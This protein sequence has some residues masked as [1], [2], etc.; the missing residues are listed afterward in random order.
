[1]RSLIPSRRAFGTGLAAAGALMASARTAAASPRPQ[2]VAHRGASGYRPEHTASAYLLAIAQGA[3][4]IEPDLVLTKD[5]A[6]VARHENEIGGTTDVASRPEFAGRRT[7]RDIDG[8]RVEGWFTEDFTLAELKTLRARERLPQLRPGSARHDGEDGVLTFAEVAALA[9]RE[10]ART[11]RTIGLCPEMKHPAHFRRLGLAFEPIMAAALKAEGLD[12]ATAPV[13]VQ[14]FEVGPLKTLSTL[15]KA[16]RVQLVL[17]EG[18]PADLPGARYADMVTAEGLKAIAA[19][20]QAVGPEWRQVLKVDGAG[21]LAGPTSLVAD[22]HA[23]GLKVFPWTVR[24]E[25]TFLPPALRRGATPA[26]H[27]DAASLLTAL[28]AAGVD[29]VFCDFPDLAVAARGG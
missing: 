28:Y 15:S 7:A 27:G 4:V 2:V 1:M 23:V 17:A 25:N 26:D 29:G 20:A 22:A 14:C 24:A 9:R 10:S 6:L 13:L 5:G 19:Y 3:D 21:A 8:E 16:P 11:G 12:A 18:G